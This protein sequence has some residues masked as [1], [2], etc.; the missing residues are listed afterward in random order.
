MKPELIIIRY[1]EIGL[2]A[3]F[4]RKNFENIFQNNIRNALKQENI[5]FQLYKT[6]ARFFVYTK[7][8]KKTIAIL[9]K[10]FAIKSISP[11]FKT[12][13]SIESMKNLALRIIKNKIN[14][15]TS[16]ALKVKR[17]G[18]HNYTSQD[19]AIILGDEIVKKTN[20]KVDLSTPDIKL[21]IEIRQ[22]NAFFFFE[23]IF[24]PGGLPLGS[25]GNILSIIKSKNNSFL[26]AWYMTRR[27]C[28]PVFL[29]L[30]K[31]FTKDVKKFM[32]KWYI[33]TEIV[34][35]KNNNLI[36]NI[37]KVAFDYK[38]D[39]VVTDHFL[40]GD[41]VKVLEEI[42][43]IKNSINVPLLQPLISMDNDFIKEK[44]KEIDL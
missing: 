42:A 28:T 16:F 18:N 30:D 10:I 8:I 17:E 33:N 34:E 35:C 39:A 3:N 22:N 36:D 14:K 20:A 9:Q 5:V 21:F 2:K 15:S 38:C 12:D 41:D 11:C 27:G 23:K 7:E 4:T 24:G 31:K 13:S 44:S 32:D 1:G 29:I 26:A 19:V 43:K 6:R 37:N 40:T 25:Q